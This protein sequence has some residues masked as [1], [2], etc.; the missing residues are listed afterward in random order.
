MKARLFLFNNIL[1]A[2]A[3]VLGGGCA[4]GG[5][6]M[7]DK[8][9]AT[10]TIFMEGRAADNLR[11]QVGWDKTPMYIE[12]EPAFTE[13]DLSKAAWVDNADGTYE[14]QLTFT[15]ESAMKLQMETIMQKGR[16]LVI[17]SAFPPEGPKEEPPKGAPAAGEKPATEQPRS[18]AWLAAVLIPQNGFSGGSLRFKPDASHEEVERIVLGVN[19]RLTAMHKM[20]R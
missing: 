4:T 20:E 8:D 19:K 9:F 6:S 14:I 13:D 7:H 16:H 17:F 2:V 5:S 18:S 11:V 10:M 12:A 1:L 15:E 3:A